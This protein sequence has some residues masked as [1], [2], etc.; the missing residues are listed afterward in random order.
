VTASVDGLEAILKR[1]ESLK[2]TSKVAVMRSAIR[3][4]LNVIGKQMK[5]DVDPQVKLGRKGVK[6]RF[7][8]GKFEITAKVGFGVGKKSKTPSPNN[9]KGNRKGGVGIDAQNIHWW[10]AGTKQRF[11]GTGKGRA[12]RGNRPKPVMDRGIMPAMQP[13]LARIAYAKSR[14]AVK[15][16][17]IK[18]GALQL[19]KEVKKLQRIT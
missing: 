3:G 18:R 7:K 1:M 11:T 14:G 15:A 4:G 8:K 16:E 17:M 19:E 9:R 10:V 5:A 13:G 2:N 6:S 12:K